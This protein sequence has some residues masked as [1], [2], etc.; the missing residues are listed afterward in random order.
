MFVFKIYYMENMT[1]NQLHKFFF[2]ISNAKKAYPKQ[3]L[4]SEHQ[5]KV[6]MLLVEF[7]N[8]VTHILRN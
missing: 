4:K 1:R 6:R 7:F 2:M 5:N 8:R 3:I